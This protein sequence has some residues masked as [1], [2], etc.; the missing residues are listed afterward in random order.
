MAFIPEEVIQEI[1]QQTDIVDVISQYVSLSKSGSNYIGSCPFHE[2]R[3]PSFSVHTEKQIFKCF[4][5]NR[6]G[7]VFGFLQEIEGIGFVEAVK[8]VAEFSH[9]PLDSRYFEGQNQRQ[10]RYQE[11]YRIHQEASDFY[12]YYLTKTTNGEEALTYLSDRNLSQETLET[13][14]VGLSPNKSE[15]LSQYLLGKGF[16][17]QQLVESGIFYLNQREELVDR[18]HG[19][20]I[21]PLRNARGQVVAFS[22]R[23]YNFEHQAK[24]LNSPETPIFE[25]N[26][27]LFNLD[28]ARLAGRQH[29]R[30]LVTEGFMD[31][32]ALSQA[33]FANSVATMGT[34]LSRKHLQQLTRIA[35]E[36][37]FVFDGDRAGQKATIRGF[38]LGKKFQDTV[39]KTIYIPGQLDPDDWIREQGAAS[40]QGL[41]DTAETEYEFY[42]EFLKKEYSLDTS[43]GLADYIE[44]L[45]HVIADVQSPIERTILIK[46]LVNEYQVDEKLLEEQL[47]VAMYEKEHAVLDHGSIPLQTPP[48]EAPV[49]DTASEIS[50]YVPQDSMEHCPAALQA[51]RQIF[52]CLMYHNEAWEFIE[53]LETPPYMFHPQSQDFFFR[54]QEYYYERGNPMPLTDIVNEMDD[55]SLNAFVTSLIWDFEVL[56]YEE[57]VLV[58]CLKV[59][60]REF[61]KQE[62]NLLKE[63]LSDY[64]RQQRY[65]EVNETITK[66]MTLTRQLKADY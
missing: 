22:G 64:E 13:Y 15:V 33:G 7:N 50:D 51:E 41:I 26:D 4:S 2:D 25:K 47:A 28:Q 18:F 53:Q 34:S 23:I 63:K 5:C 21:F 1:R 6:G 44:R 3:N 56:D 59:I 24:Y 38:E 10:D 52:V 54:L 8:Q 35:K 48:E 45:I 11:L 29:N 49:F 16:S 43:Q 40:F 37:V 20:I 36:I 31:V 14:Q 12:H 9:V 61:L 66:I 46:D 30:V 39:F 62:I 55:P 17:A 65:N 19:R 58:D 27:L 60:D 57:Q 32:I 42:R